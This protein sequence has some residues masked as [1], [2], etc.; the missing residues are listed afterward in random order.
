MRFFSLFP[1]G[2]DGVRTN[3]T[4]GELHF[5]PLP[6]G[7]ENATVDILGLIRKTNRPREQSPLELQIGRIWPMLHADDCTATGCTRGPALI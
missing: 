4:C 3:G 7:A 2:E 1:L 6:Q 5:C